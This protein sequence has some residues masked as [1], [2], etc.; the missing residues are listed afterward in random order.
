MT[1]SKI[2][3]IDNGHGIN[4]PGKRS[5]EWPDGNQLFEWEFN[6]DISNRIKRQLGMHHV[7]SFIL[8]PEI[9]DISLSERCKRANALHDK[10][11]AYQRD[12]ILISIHAN[13]GGGSGWECFTS[14]GETRSDAMA[15][16]FYKKAK[17][18]FPKGTKIRTDYSDGD[19]DKESAFYI[20]KHTKCPA[21]LTENFFMDTNSDCKLLM[22]DSFRE[23]IAN[24]HTE[25]IMEIIKSNL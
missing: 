15:T 23:Q 24:V 7:S 19:P 4:T 13:A 22:T 12:T 21:I 9:E 14:P 3:I 17:E 5:P 10:F 25:A 18:L 8:V 2:I 16:I 1:T 20:L 11:K 6:R